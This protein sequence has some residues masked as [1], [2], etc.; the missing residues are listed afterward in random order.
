M[1]KM[2]LGPLQPEQRIALI[3]KLEEQ[4]MSLPAKA[5]RIT[6]KYTSVFSKSKVVM[7]WDDEEEVFAMMEELFMDPENQDILK[8]IERVEG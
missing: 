8:M 7:D 5:K 2:E 3:E 4:G 6:A 1:L